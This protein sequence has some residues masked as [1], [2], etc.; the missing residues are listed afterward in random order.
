[1]T[2]AEIKSITDSVL[3]AINP[4]LGDI[5]EKINDVAKVVSAI[6][7]RTTNHMPTREQVAI[8]INAHVSSCRSSRRW[9]WGLIIGALVTIGA[10][11]LQTVR[12]S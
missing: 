1:M 11:I 3:V 10:A 9:Q 5:H 2:H 6:D 8:A 7:E 12:M 4:A